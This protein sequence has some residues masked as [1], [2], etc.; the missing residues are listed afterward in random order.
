MIPNNLKTCPACG[1][2]V[3]VRRNVG[4]YELNCLECKWDDTIFIPLP[5][6]R[7]HKTEPVIKRKPKRRKVAA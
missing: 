7:K 4:Q 1:G 2:Y 6:K 5:T 3:N